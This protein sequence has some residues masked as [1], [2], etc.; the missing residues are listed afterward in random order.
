MNWQHT[1]CD[2]YFFQ[3]CYS[4]FYS[5]EYSL[6]WQMFHARWR[7]TYIL[8]LLDEILYKCQSEPVD[9][10]CWSAQLYAYWFSDY[11]ACRSLIRGSWSLSNHGFVYFSLQFYQILPHIFWHFVDTLL[12]T[13]T[14]RI[15][16]LSWRIDPFIII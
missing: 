13:H 12:G 8:L 2:F 6:F 3:I 10:W 5:P 11:W 4:V 14:L 1:S 9:W 15:V 16:M 7:I